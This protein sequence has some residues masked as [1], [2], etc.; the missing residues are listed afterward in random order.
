LKA[1]GSIARG[2]ALSHDGAGLATPAVIA[3]D[4][5]FAVALEAKDATHTDYVKALVK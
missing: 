5:M 4:Q 1:T 2:D 3:N